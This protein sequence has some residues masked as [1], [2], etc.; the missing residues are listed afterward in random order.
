MTEQF[1]LRTAVD[2]ALPQ[3][4]ED[5]LDKD[6]AGSNERLAH[7]TALKAPTHHPEPDTE[8]DGSNFTQLT[9]QM[10]VCSA[11]EEALSV[12]RSSSPA[13]ETSHRKIADD[14]RNS[15]TS[16]VTTIPSTRTSGTSNSEEPYIRELEKGVLV[17]PRLPIPLDDVEN[18][19]SIK[20]RLEDTLLNLFKP[21]PGLDPSLSWELVMAG[22]CKAPLK[23]STVLT[24]C[25]EPHRKRLKKLLKSQKWL[26]ST[27]YPVFV[28]IDPV[29]QWS[30]V[31]RRSETT[32]TSHKG[33][34]LGAGLGIGLGLGVLSLV[35]IF[36]CLMYRRRLLLR[37]GYMNARETDENGNRILSWIRR[38]D[39][40]ATTAD[41]VELEAQYPPQ[42]KTMQQGSPVP[43]F[44]VP[45][46]ITQH[47]HF[48]QNTKRLSVA[49]YK[50]RFVYIQANLPERQTLCGAPALVCNSHT[51]HAYFTIGGTILI[52]G[53]VYGLATRHSFEHWNWEQCSSQEEP[54]FTGGPETE[55]EPGSESESDSDSE[56][57]SPW[58]FMDGERDDDSNTLEASFPTRRLRDEVDCNSS[59]SSISTPELPEPQPP[60][61]ELLR[62]GRLIGTVKAPNVVASDYGPDHA[63]LDWAIIELNNTQCWAVNRVATEGSSCPEDIAEVAETARLQDGEVTI[64]SGFTGVVKGWL[65]QTPV[66]LR[67]GCRTHEAY[68]IIIESYLVRGDSGAWVVKDGMFCGHIIAQKT[69]SPIAFMLPAQGILEG[70]KSWVV[71][72]SWLRLN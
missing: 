31:K 28:V 60:S 50:P 3:V 45:P 7:L 4:R 2:T 23:P 1:A 69:F 16:Y 18:W 22:P 68:Q 17:A 44:D 24:C 5:D 13:S 26:A 39:S 11:S 37:R 64:V 72:I 47:T 55:P 36:L 65:R 14:S 46:S 9:T 33:T 48:R 29:H 70:I 67:M 32:P 54:R 6:L 38:K 20:H 58:V 8:P 34:S 42:A 40:V 53:S 10:E 19:S 71:D 41:S 59:S 66:M 35:A 52:N 56:S 62:E 25:N 21:K 51:Q 43:G 12:A 63:K 49:T 27:G 61:N 57:T 30:L 15:G